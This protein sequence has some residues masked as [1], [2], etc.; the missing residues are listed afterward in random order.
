MGLN[1]IQG[2]YAP[3]SRAC[4][5]FLVP[6]DKLVRA[7]SIL[8]TVNSL[9]NMVAPPAAGIL[10]AGFGLIPILVVS[11]ICFAVTAVMDLLINIPY[12]KQQADRNILRTM[13]S[14]MRQAFNFVG[15]NTILIKLA[16]LMFI[17]SLLIPGVFN[18]GVPVFVMQRLGMS[19]GYFGLGR[20]IAFSGGILGGTIAGA[21][22]KKLTVRSVP[23]T[24]I[25]L[26]LSIVPIGFAIWINISYFMAFAV[27][28]ASDF[29]SALVLVLWMVPI[30][31]YIQTITPPELSGKV[32]SLLS[33]LPMI[34]MGLGLLLFGMLFQ[35]FDSAPW[36]IV[37]I[38]TAICCIAALLLRKHFREVKVEK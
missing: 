17:L 1:T 11:G 23:L 28:V 15:K 26:G 25:L 19:T 3:T 35:R 30:W 38:T 27:I 12:K 36:H 2:I 7:N 13:K 34:A 9:A 10:L 37:F 20:A 33:G 6:K 5:P 24:S 4:V 31:A 21:L 8:E 14:D 22:G 29:I 18:V 16:I 32:M